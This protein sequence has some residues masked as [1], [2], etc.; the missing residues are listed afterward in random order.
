LFLI[1]LKAI[2]K[3]ERE[4]GSTL[5]T[6]GFGSGN[7]NDALMESIVDVGN[8]NSSYID[9]VREADKVLGDEIGAT[10]ITV[11]RNRATIPPYQAPL[12]QALP[13]GQKRRRQRLS[14]RICTHGA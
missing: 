3:R 5:S 1:E 8:Y 10:L 14:R 7:Y 12:G 4:K 6:V 9:S 13:L 2:V 11:A